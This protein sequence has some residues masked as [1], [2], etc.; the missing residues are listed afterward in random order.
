[1]SDL[2]R[3]HPPET[4]PV[5]F[6]R[7]AALPSGY[8]GQTI[9]SA[10]QSAHAVV[11]D[12]AAGGRSGQP[13]PREPPAVPLYVAESRWWSRPG[14]RV[15]TRRAPGWA[16]PCRRETVAKGVLGKINLDRRPR[17]PS[18]WATTGR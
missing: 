16:M 5:L 2:L 3:A 1:M 13:L 10:I 15:P 11:D 17:P 6:T 12:L 4:R 18:S 9:F 7:D 14:R 8:I